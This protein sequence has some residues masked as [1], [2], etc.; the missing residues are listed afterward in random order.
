[1][2]NVAISRCCLANFC[3]QQKQRQINQQKII[4]HAYTAIALVTVAVKICLIKL[5]ETE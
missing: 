1:M 3:K 4:T 2:R 5:P